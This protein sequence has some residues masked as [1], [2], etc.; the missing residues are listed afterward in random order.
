MAR[1][2]GGLLRGRTLVVPKHVRATEEKVRQALFNI[3]G[4]SV[5][6]ARVLDGCAGSGAFGLE[7]LSRGAARAVFME[8][9]PASIKAIRE[10]LSKI[11]SEPLDGT[12]AVYPGDVLRQ[13]GRVARA[14]APFDIAIFDPPY[15]ANAGKKILNAMSEYAM[16][17]SSGVLCLEHAVRDESPSK[18]GPLALVKQHR[19]GG[20]VLSFYGTRSSCA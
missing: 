16:L 18:V 14:E 19:Y 3:L 10:N 1:I 2:S 6:G 5:A 4:S 20:T 17:T 9:H 8:S 7:A 15:E 13:L 12:W 11:A